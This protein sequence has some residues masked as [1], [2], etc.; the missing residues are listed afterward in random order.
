MVSEFGVGVHLDEKNDNHE[1][2]DLPKYRRGKT[3]IY[4]KNEPTYMI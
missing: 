3:E 1:D 2:M 4:K